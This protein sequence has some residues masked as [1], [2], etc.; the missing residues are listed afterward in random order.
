MLVELVQFNNDLGQLQSSHSHSHFA[1]VVFLY[2]AVC[3]GFCS[4]VSL[5]ESRLFY[6]PMYTDEGDCPTLVASGTFSPTCLPICQSDLWKVW[7][8]FAVPLTHWLSMDLAGCVCLR[9]DLVATDYYT[10]NLSDVKQLLPRTR[11]A[12]W[13]T[14][15]LEYLAS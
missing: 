13:C 5:A 3:L 15:K 12:F 8:L 6:F 11:A 2:G 4:S 7:V 10:C 14:G 1:R 9:F